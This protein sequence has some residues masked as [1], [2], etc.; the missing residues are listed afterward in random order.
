[1]TTVDGAKLEITIRRCV[2]VENQKMLRT[3]VESCSVLSVGGSIRKWFSSK[4]LE[5]RLRAYIVARLCQDARSEVTDLVVPVSRKTTLTATK[6]MVNTEGS[7][8]GTF[9]GKV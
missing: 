8:T 3:D 9:A 1:M 4:F 6:C 5:R 2:G 7:T